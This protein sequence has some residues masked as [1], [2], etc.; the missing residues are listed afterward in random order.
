M[1]SKCAMSPSSPCK[2]D[3]VPGLPG[4]SAWAL[5]AP[6]VSARVRAVRR[7]RAQRG[8]QPGA[9]LAAVAQEVQPGVLGRCLCQNQSRHLPPGLHRLVWAGDITCHV[10]KS[11]SGM[12]ALFMHQEHM[13]ICEKGE[14]AA[15][16]TEPGRTLSPATAQNWQGWR[17][18]LT[19]NAGA[20]AAGGAWRPGTGSGRV[21]E[22]ASETICSALFG[23]PNTF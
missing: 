13:Y 22:G 18:G 3:R 15:A 6:T 17:Q 11:N 4:I 14:S 20:G 2:D 16:A 21:C 1:R 7:D 19:G 9:R 23:S 10:S 5:W 12:R 8:G